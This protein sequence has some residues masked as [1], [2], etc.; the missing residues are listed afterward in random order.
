ML[1][2]IILTVTFFSLA[3]SLRSH[4]GVLLG[5]GILSLSRRWSTIM[6][7]VAGM[8]P[9]GESKGKKDM[10]EFWS[11][12]EWAYTARIPLWFLFPLPY[13]GLVST[14]Y[15]LLFRTLHD[16]ESG[17]IFLHASFVFAPDLEHRPRKG[18]ISPDHFQMLCFWFPNAFPKSMVD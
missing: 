8:L 12:C 16:L 10:S 3:R 14:V 5:Y 11:I 13:L 4:L 1:V 6:V 2:I 17:R 18:V 7:G 9:I 15:L